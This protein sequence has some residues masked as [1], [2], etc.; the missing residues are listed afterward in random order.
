MGVVGIGA[1]TLGL[2]FACVGVTPKDTRCE[3]ACVAASRCGLLPSALGGS[4]AVASEASQEDCI[5][6]CVASKEDSRAVDGLLRI[7]AESG[8]QED[9][10]CNGAGTM[11]CEELIATLGGDAATA[12]LRVTSTLTVRMVSAVSHAAHFSVESLCCFDARDRSGDIEVI[13][14]MFG[15]THECFELIQEDLERIRDAL[16][17]TD[18]MDPPDLMAA[19]MACQ[20]IRDRWRSAPPGEEPDLGVMPCHFARM[21]TRLAALGIPTIPEDCPIDDPMIV[22]VL[23]MALDGIRTDWN[24]DLGGVLIDDEGQV[25]DAESIRATIVE[26]ID[27]EIEG[28]MSFLE[29]ACQEFNCDAPPATSSCNHGPLCSAAD[30]LEDSRACDTSLCDADLTPP[31][32]DCSFFGITSI[33]L[34]YRD[35]RGLEVFSEPIEGC[36]TLVEL[37]ARFEDVKI[38]S[39]VPIAVVSGVLPSNFFAEGAPL[40][41]DGSFSWFLEGT[42]RWIS[43]GNAELELPSPL[44]D[45]QEFEYGNPLERLGWVPHRLPTGQAC[46]NQP[47]LCETYFN[48]NCD[49]GLDNDGDGQ[50]DAE[51]AW[52]DRLL[53]ELASRCVIVEPGRGPAPGCEDAGPSLGE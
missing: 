15:S 47:M 11:V 1:A 41:G 18:P 48:R 3:A 32:R 8:V 29:E 21:S 40:S 24:L 33:T 25:R 20:D 23:D 2:L 6:R 46:D 7:L 35:E 52:C 26:E 27:D 19:D 49:D 16:L 37:S 34:G 51:T 44:L 36:A 31:G 5:E 42:K 9:P 22:D 38:G 13:H 39:L 10:L 30:C 4:V 45:F 43:A 53:E 14:D 28:P 17:P 12:E 50:V